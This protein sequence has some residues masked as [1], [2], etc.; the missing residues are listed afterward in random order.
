MTSSHAVMQLYKFDLN[1]SPMKIGVYE[2]Q[3]SIWMP[4][5]YSTYIQGMPD[6]LRGVLISGESGDL[7]HMSNTY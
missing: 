4:C 1:E 6:M 2:V 5:L 7:W 3:K